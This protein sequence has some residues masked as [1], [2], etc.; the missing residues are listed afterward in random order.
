MNGFPMNVNGWDI[1]LFAV[2]VAMSSAIAYI[3]NPRMKAFV[4]LLPIPF[5][6]ANLSLGRPVDATN[7]MGILVLYLFTQGVRILHRVLGWSIVAAIATSS[8]AY[9]LIGAGLALVVPKSEAAFWIS[10]VVVL[11]AGLVIHFAIPA[12][13]EPGHRTSLPVWKKLPT[14]AATVAFVVAMKFYLQGFMTVFPMVTI[15]GLYESRHSLATTCR[16]VGS[17]MLI[18]L[19]M[20][21]VMRIAQHHLHL[22]IGA[23]LALGWVAFIAF[24]LP[25]NRDIWNRRVEPEDDS[26]EVRC[27]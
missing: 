16:K 19:P 4:L 15:I 1:L 3:H 14:I 12:V 8:A 23:S 18:M 10:S 11:A 20:I 22:G 9:S 21:V 27:A 2:V 26:K 17:L 25:L 5:S 13:D 6:I 24:L 7:V